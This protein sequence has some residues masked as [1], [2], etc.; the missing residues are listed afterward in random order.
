[1]EYLENK[2][3]KRYA[4]LY[5]KIIML[6]KIKEDSVTN[7]EVYLVHSGKP[8]IVKLL[9]LLKL[10]YEFILIPVKIS[11]CSFW[12]EISKEILKF[13]PKLTML[14]VTK[15]NVKNKNQVGGL[16]LPDFKAHPRAMSIHCGIG[17]RMGNRSIEQKSLE[18]NPHVCGQLLFDKG[19]K[20]FTEQ[21]NHFFS[22]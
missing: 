6:K 15:A 16:I 17:I 2:L 7:G 4:N 11:V 19:T 3:D 18:I 5:T 22:K 10:I 13:I 8:N 21:N 12:G 14:T 1:M 20:Q 9:I